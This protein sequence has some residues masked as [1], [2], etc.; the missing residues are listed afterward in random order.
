LSSFKQWRKRHSSQWRKP[1]A[2]GERTGARVDEISKRTMPRLFQ[3]TAGVIGADSEIGRA[4]A[5]K[6]APKDVE[7]FAIELSAGRASE[8]H[9]T[10]VSVGGK[11]TILEADVADTTAMSAAFSK[12][13]PI[14]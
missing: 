9:A 14:L 6:L 10:I 11:C 7:I 8:S 13:N 3:K 5:E 4:I 2:I 1:L 12:D